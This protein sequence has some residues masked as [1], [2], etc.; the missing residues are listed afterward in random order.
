ML[1]HSGWVRAL[2]RSLVA[3]GSAADDVEQQVWLTAL[4]KPPRHGRNL[5]AW[6]SSVVRSVVGQRHR[7]TERQRRYDRKLQSNTSAP[8]AGRAGSGGGTVQPPDA[9]AER[10][11]T[12][13]A[14]AALVSELEEPYG[15]AVYL[16]Y[17]EDLSV[18]DVGQRLGVPTNTAQTRLHRGVEKLRARMKSRFGLDWKQRCVI[19]LTP[20]P[21]AS[22][23][24][25][26]VT[27][28]AMSTKAKWSL[29]AAVLLAIPMYQILQTDPLEDD[30]GSV[31]EAT[32]TEVETTPDSTAMASV[33]ESAT[34]ERSLVETAAAPTSANGHLVTVLHAGSLQPAGDVEVLY[35]DRGKGDDDSFSQALFKNNL[36]I[37]GALDLH[38]QRFQTNHLGQVQLPP[39]T[40]YA[41]V[42][43]RTQEKYGELYLLDD[44]GDN[45]FEQVEILLQKR[46]DIEVEVL[47][48]LGH[49]A[50]DV[51]VVYQKQHTPGHANNLKKAFTDE[52][53]VAV[54]RN[55]QVRLQ[56][57]N[58]SFTHLI[59]V[60][61]P[62]HDK[63]QQSFELGKPPLQRIRFQLPPTV[64]VEV[65]VQY[66][67]GSSV[68][69]GSPVYLHTDYFEQINGFKS[70]PGTYSMANSQDSTLAYIRDGVARYPRVGQNLILIAGARF[71]G[72]GM[73]TAMGRSGSDP[74]SALEITIKNGVDTVVYHA[75]LQRP[76][77]STIANASVHLDVMLRLEDALAAPGATRAQYGMRTS[78][79]ADGVLSFSQENHRSFMMISHRPDEPGMV[80]WGFVHIPE[81]LRAPASS[82]SK[83]VNKSQVLSP[84][85]MGEELILSG[86]VLD[87]NEQALEGAEVELRL[88]WVPSI[89]GNPAREYEFLY[90]NTI[91]DQDGRFQ[92]RG[93]LQ[94]P[95]GYLG[96][97]V[98]NDG[99]VSGKEGGMQL[100]ISPSR[101]ADPDEM[102]VF[103]FEVGKADQKFVLQSSAVVEGRIQ[104]DPGVNPRHLRLSLKHMLEGEEGPINRFNR[105][106]GVDGKFRFA[107]LEA[108]SGQLE[109][110][111]WLTGEVVAQSQPFAIRKGQDCTPEDWKALDLRGHLFPHTVRAVDSTG[112]Q[113]EELRI[114][115][116]RNEKIFLASR[117]APAHF[118]STSPQAM[119]RISARGFLD[120]PLILIG[121]D[122]T[123]TMTAAI[124]VEVR[125]PKGVQL[126]AN[127]Q[128]Q[129]QARQLN[130]TM[131]LETWS[132]SG[133]SR[134]RAGQESVQL[135]VPATG[136]WHIGLSYHGLGDGPIDP[137]AP[138]VMPQLS[139]GQSTHVIEVAPG[140]NAVVE[141]PLEQK[142]IDQLIQ[143]LS[144]Q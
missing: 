46:V 84:I 25:T 28:I 117:S 26:T 57:G 31:A 34:A 3:D 89:H 114:A 92:I 130:P 96:W 12:F 38:A 113:I 51:A 7:E 20:L 77:G 142:S 82:G 65:R 24:V 68:R 115:Y 79:D 8:S 129:I 13:Q 116:Q 144:R 43:A 141:L 74:N 69:D 66:A 49:P 127:T 19:F 6:L 118:L 50:A 80:E 71:S 105:I 37:E 9:V 36:G 47:D 44:L 102:R 15:S 104:L 21:A 1:A 2:A 85:L 64:P 81:P 40:S 54:L 55:M 125:L 73:Q 14:L 110:T 23:P 98:K 109:I 143:V 103:A 5:K 134:I 131:Q 78:T 87:H 76:D 60:D 72:T 123:E 29:A 58:P 108:G 97:T 99:F 45:Q 16:R 91:T 137:N 30:S 139:T 107:G 52:D 39:R 35:F 61:L 94:D 140:Q 119:V 70:S 62:L 106:D 41:W 138:V 67:D 100:S 17:F 101:A 122:H 90:L 33:A 88:P 22:V 111:T 132:S 133:A 27:A 124:A 11:E 4:E 121:S 128:W 83:L 42:A 136:E 86:I 126:P 75:K 59:A 56:G 53:G 10:M 135:M 112:K 95:S 63:L 18:A 48:H 120:S 93:T 32:V